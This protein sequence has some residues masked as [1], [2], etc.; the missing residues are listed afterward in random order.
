MVDCKELRKA[1]NGKEKR[2]S[3]SAGIKKW[4]ICSVNGAE[5]NSSVK[6]A[7]TNCLQVNRQTEDELLLCVKR[8]ENEKLNIKRVAC[9]HNAS[10]KLV[11]WVFFTFS[12]YHSSKWSISVCA[13]WVL[14]SNH[15]PV[16]HSCRHSMA[17]KLRL[18]RAPC[19]S[20][21]TQAFS[22]LH[23][24]SNIVSPNRAAFVWPTHTHLVG[25]VR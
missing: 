10:Q 11:E 17:D 25:Q 14:P 18:I 7:N 24:C 13:C 6:A 5:I 3:E 4:K 21:V 23:E 12:S 16:V 1:S 22:L 9:S 8:D 19:I 20:A 15:I 2:T